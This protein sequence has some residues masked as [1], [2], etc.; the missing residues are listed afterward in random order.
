M[1]ENKFFGIAF[2]A[3]LL[4]SFIFVATQIPGAHSTP[5]DLPIGLVLEDGGNI[6]QTFVEMIQKNS[7]ATKEAPFKW[8]VLKNEQEMKEK[9]ANQEL[10]GAIYIPKDFSE[11]YASFQTPTPTSAMLKI[12]INQGKNTNVAN[13]VTQ[14]LSTMVE[15]MNDNVSAQLLAVTEKNNIPL[16]ANQARIYA[17]PIQSEIVNVHETGK[18][19]NAPLSY[20]QPIWMSSLIS[21]ILLWFT[22]RNRKFNSVME[23]IKFRGF[24]ALIAMTIGLFGGYL[25][26]W[27]STWML[28]YEFADFNYV[29]LFLSLT[30]ATFIL[31][32]LAITTWIKYAALPIF[33]LLMF[34]GLPLLQIAPEMLPSFYADWI[35]P[36]L[37]FRFMF[38]GLKEILFFSGEL[39]S[40]AAV[41]LCWIAVVSIVVLLLSV[42]KRSS[43]KEDK[44]AEGTTSVM[45]GEGV[46][47]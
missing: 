6:G 13:I 23:Q 43:Y 41:S 21:A 24:Q 39:W 19:S 14:A 30:C 42:V 11:K 46:E 29:A 38:E 45:E 44:S 27:Y 22:G 34:F 3:V 20:F 40:S 18:L 26:T 16:N 36:W 31:L 37:P 7:Q 28:D 47:V 25:L 9:L 15:K 35:Y 12:Y 33:V 32:I 1:K 4:L 10:Y 5:K 2:V 8:V 17:S